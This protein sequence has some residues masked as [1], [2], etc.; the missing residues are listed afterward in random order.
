MH[1]CVRSDY[2]TL[3][4]NRGGGV[5]SF[6]CCLEWLHTIFE[7]IAQL[8]QYR[9]AWHTTWEE[10]TLWEK[11]KTKNANKIKFTSE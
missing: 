7:W 8:T 10:G 1:D 9:P 5:R 11:K 4:L 2:L 3:G 6:R